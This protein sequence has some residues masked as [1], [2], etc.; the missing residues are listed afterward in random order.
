MEEQVTKSWSRK[1]KEFWATYNMLI[2]MLGVGAALDYRNDDRFKS[3]NTTVEDNHKEFISLNMTV[4]KH[5]VYIEDMKE[6]IAKLSQS[7]PDGTSAPS[8]SESKNTAFFTIPPI[9]TDK[10]KK[11]YYT[12][13]R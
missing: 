13:S 6:D 9:I 11:P 1:M 12:A 4:V 2:T 5:D 8:R 10:L 3:L 7:E